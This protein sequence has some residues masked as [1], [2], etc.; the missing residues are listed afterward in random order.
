MKIK[1]L[2][3]SLLAVCMA[4]AFV[5]CGE[6]SDTA[7]TTPE[8][9]NYAVT[10]G[11][12]K[13]TAADFNYYYR[14]TVDAFY[15][16]WA[17]GYILGENVADF[18]PAVPLNEQ[19]YD[20]ATETT[21]ADYMIR[22]AL[23]DAK[24][25][26]ILSGLAKAANFTLP[27]EYKASLETQRSYL[28]QNADLY[29]YADVDSFLGAYY[30]PGYTE[31]SYMAYKERQLTA[32]AYEAFH[33]ESL[34][35]SEAVL[36]SQDA[37]DYDAYSSYSYDSIY[38]SYTYFN[39]MEK[40]DGTLTTPEEARALMEAAATELA[41]ATTAEELEEKVATLKV[42]DDVSLH[43]MHTKNTP[44]NALSTAYTVLTEWV[45]AAERKA[46]DVGRLPITGTSLV[47]DDIA[48]V[49][50]GY[51]V[52][53]FGGKNDNNSKMGNVRHLLVKFEGGTTDGASGETVYSD[54]EKAAAGKKA[55]EYLDMW[56]NGAANE[57]S[58]IELVK[59]YSQD[60]YLESGG[61][62]TNIAPRSYYVENF[63][64]WATDPTRMA[65]ETGIIETMYGYHVMYFVGWSD[66]TYRDYMITEQLRDADQKVW[67]QETLDAVEAEILDYSGLELNL[68]LDN[69]E[70]DILDYSGLELDM[71]LD[72]GATE[73][74]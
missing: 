19:Y 69:V 45:T 59:K 55:Q 73:L 28:S 8:P 4:A 27:A 23:S 65:G 35:Y 2:L 70:A 29:G 44:R 72:T 62:Y 12:H 21:W 48:D 22:E 67:L 47:D 39:E 38:L 53:I 24:Y 5:G 36:R 33:R 6:D 64:N 1:K 34:T 17:N 3:C 52:V 46:G 56:K 42:R 14:E 16:D 15:N 25:D 60:T 30:G 49:T 41:T 51:Y 32:E 74:Y 26:Y 63:E 7:P 13:L 40:E 18:D 31:S 58:F 9:E 71:V 20:A 43:P 66:L 11:D 37:G 57:D 54:Q 61:L 10:I 68:V 50:N